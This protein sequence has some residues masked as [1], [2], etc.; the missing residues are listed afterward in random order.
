[1]QQSHFF[2]FRLFYWN[3]M[4]AH[5]V[6]RVDSGI[7]KEGCVFDGLLISVVVSKFG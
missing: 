1:M 2:R 4:T 5:L 7:Y 3:Q 6:F